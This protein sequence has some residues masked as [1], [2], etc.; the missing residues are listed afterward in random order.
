MVLLIL[1]VALWW[2]AHLYKR[3]APHP[4]PDNRRKGMVA[5]ALRS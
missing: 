5:V 2:G 4:G 1:G 3:M